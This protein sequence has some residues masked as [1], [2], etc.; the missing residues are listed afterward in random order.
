MIVHTLHVQRIRF[1]IL[2]NKLT[3]NVSAYHFMAHHT[4]NRSVTLIPNAQSMSAGTKSS[5][6]LTANTA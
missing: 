5:F 1:I 6:L 3:L 2:P 4:F